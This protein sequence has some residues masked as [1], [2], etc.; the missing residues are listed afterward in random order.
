MLHFGKIPK[1]IGQIWGKFSKILAN[2]AKFWEKSRKKTVIFNENF[3]IRERCKG[4]QNGAK[5]CIV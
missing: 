2:F 4:F 1:K 5:E 3:E